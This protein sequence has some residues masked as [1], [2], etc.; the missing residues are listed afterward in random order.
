MNPYDHARLS[1]RIHGGSWADYH[2]LHAWF[3]A[4]KA[5]HCHFTHRSLRHHEEGIAEA[6]AVFGATV[7]NADGVAVAVDTLARQHIGE[8]CRY[9]PSAADWLVDFDLPAWFPAVPPDAGDL[10]AISARRFG[11]EARHYLPLHRWFLATRAWTDGPAHLFFRH[12]AF[13]I[14]ETEHRFGPALANGD[15]AVP[16]RV[17]AEHH[18]RA[19]LGRLPAAPDLFRRMKGQRWM[20]QATSPDRIGLT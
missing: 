11:G 14:H 15:G 8:D 6:I 9:L 1:A 19:V 16:T 13:G 7:T 5:A 10:A 18:V 17:V 20:L 3:D 12:Q 4:S 2:A